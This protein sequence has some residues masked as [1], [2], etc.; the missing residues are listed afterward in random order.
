ML[1]QINSHATGGIHF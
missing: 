1:T